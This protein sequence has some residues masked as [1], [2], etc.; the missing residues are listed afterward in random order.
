M[1]RV[2]A[3][4]S[5]SARLILGFISILLGAGTLASTATTTWQAPTPAEID[6]WIARYKATGNEYAKVFL[7]LVAEET[8]LIETFDSPGRLIS[9]ARLFPTSWCTNRRAIREGK[10]P[11]IAMFVPSM[12]N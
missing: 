1:G 11:S 7:N 3:Q 10:Q 6:Q 2:R 8:K 9:G 4:M 5:R 12:A